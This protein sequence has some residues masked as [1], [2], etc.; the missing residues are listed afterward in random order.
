MCMC[1]RGLGSHVVCKRMCG[2]GCG[3]EPRP[4]LVWQRV[5]CGRRAVESSIVA[6]SACVFS[7]FSLTADLTYASRRARRLQEQCRIA[8]QCDLPT[9]LNCLNCNYRY[10]CVSFQCVRTFRE[11]SSRS[12]ARGDPRHGAGLRTHGKCRV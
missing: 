8:D 6:T 4:V 7:V 2:S 3:Y 5:E 10:V 9:I 12:T 11:S 1:T